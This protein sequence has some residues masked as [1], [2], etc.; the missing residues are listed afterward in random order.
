MVDRP[1]VGFRL[2]LHMSSSPAPNQFRR[3]SRA[4]RRE[5][6]RAQ[7]MEAVED[8]LSEGGL[9]TD[10]LVDRIVARAGISRSNFYVYFEDKTTLLQELFED[11][12]ATL[13]QNAGPWWELP[14]TADEK[15]LRATLDALFQAYLPHR[16]VWAAGVE[17]AS[18][19]P[20]MRTRFEQL[21]NNAI[22]DLAK[23]IRDGQANGTV[24]GHHD[25]DT[26]AAWLVWM[27]E[28]GLY[29]LVSE[30]DGPTYE[31]LL[32]QFTRIY[33]DLLY[34]GTR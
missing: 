29:Q 26:L 30:A 33:W 23:H 1:D 31:A 25:P 24:R 9:Y 2:G 20:A 3:S 10:L 4:K 17:A 11:M 14:A 28:R 5:V 18:Y 19:D 13:T 12:V 6:M 34:A 27:T 15:A 8:M 7:L 16:H 22:A 32:D 21:M